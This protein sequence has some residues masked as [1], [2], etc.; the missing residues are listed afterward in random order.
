MPT[1]SYDA[2]ASASHSW[3]LTKPLSIRP[4]RSFVR[5]WRSSRTES[6]S[7]RRDVK[8]TH[9]PPASKSRWYADTHPGT[10]FSTIEKITNHSTETSGLP[11]YS[12]G[13]MAPNYTALPNTAAKCL[14]WYEHF[15]LNMSS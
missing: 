14:D 11:G 13:S 1:A 3:R 6:T 2:S 4:T 8:A 12:G 10:T 5:S 7:W 15:P 9:Y